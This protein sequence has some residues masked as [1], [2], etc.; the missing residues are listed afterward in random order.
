MHFASKIA[1][2]LQGGSQ[3]QSLGI[4]D[5][6]FELWDRECAIEPLIPFFVES[7][8]LLNFIHNFEHGWQANLERTFAEQP[9]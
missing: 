6:I 3:A 2:R 4:Q 7:R 9:P 5:C 8:L 1:Q